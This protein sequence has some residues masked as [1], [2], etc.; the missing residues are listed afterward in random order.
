MNANLVLAFRNIF[1]S[2][3]R[4]LCL[5]ALMCAAFLAITLIKAGYADMFA[6]IKASFAQSQGDVT[7]SVDG[8]SGMSIAAYRAFKDKLLSGG[9]VSAVKAAVPVQG[10]IGGDSASAPVSG[11]ALEGSF[12]AW[13]G[14]DGVVKA[15]LGAALADSL[16]VKAGDE[17]SGMLN[18]SGFAFRVEKVVKTEAKARDR[19]YLLMPFEALA[20]RE[21]EAKATQIMLWFSDSRAD[22]RAL[23]DEL[24]AMPEFAAYS[25]SAYELGNTMV[26]SIV[27]VYEDNFIVVLIVVA[28]T[29]L[30][31]L[32]NASLLSA[33]ERGPE[34]GTMLALGNRR[35]ALGFVIALESL[36]LALAACLIGGGLTLAIS[37]IANAAGGITLPPPPT[38]TSPLRVGFKPETS[39]FLLA[40]LVSFLC[41]LAAALLSAWN[42]RRSAITELLFER[43]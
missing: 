4:S 8:S 42:L 20:E 10:L 31:A 13:R 39:A 29:M 16:G 2:P 12:D 5:L 11:F 17:F 43:N 37:A 32:A 24:K 19:F 1:R 3:K 26:N 41:A 38:A 40:C 15:E 33:W 22:K 34:W 36:A 14:D 25:C 35:S 28:A 21:P 6:N 23:I 7:F 27:K 30:L 9:K 18:D